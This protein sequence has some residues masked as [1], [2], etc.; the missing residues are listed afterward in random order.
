MAFRIEWKEGAIRQLEKLKGD[1]PLRIS[2]KIGELAE[3]PFSR[4]IK[5]LRGENGFR[6]RVGDYRVIMDID[7]GNSVICI[8]RIGH[9]RNIYK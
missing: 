7:T 9:R 8:L 3:N 1:I 6:L 4:G 5:R 2:K